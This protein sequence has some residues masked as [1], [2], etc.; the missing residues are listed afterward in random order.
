M[1][2]GEGEGGGVLHERGGPAPEGN[3]V[4]LKDT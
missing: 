1:S 2:D 4:C 3:T